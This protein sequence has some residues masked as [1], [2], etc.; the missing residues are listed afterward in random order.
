MLIGGCFFVG[1]LSLLYEF[2]IFFFLPRSSV[3]IIFTFCPAK[4]HLPRSIPMPML[5]TISKV[6]LEHVNILKPPTAAQYM[7]F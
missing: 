1:L 3:Q 6:L 7:D 2:L 4:R 5:G